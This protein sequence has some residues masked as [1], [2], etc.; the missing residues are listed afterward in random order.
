MKKVSHLLLAGATLC[1]SGCLTVEKAKLPGGD[2]THVFVGN[3]GKYL[4]NCVPMGCGNLNENP[5]CRFVMFRDDVTMDKMQHRFFAECAKVGGD[6][7]NIAY[8]TSDNIFIEVSLWSFS[9][10]I[11]Y[12]WTTREIQISGT[13]R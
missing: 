8:H 11:P 10:P 7:T 6:V 1:L 12:L 9:I 2:G 3:Y 13:V 5:E 4:F